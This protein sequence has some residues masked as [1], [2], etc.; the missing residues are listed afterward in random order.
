MF[1][2][3][4]PPPPSGSKPSAGANNMASGGRHTTFSVIGGDVII[5]GNLVATVDLHIDGR[6]D[7]DLRCANLV[8]GQDSQLRGAIVADSAKLA[9]LVEGSIDAKSLVIHASARIIGDVTYDSLTIEQGA[10][11]DGK[12][13]SRTHGA[14]QGGA[15]PA[16]LLVADQAAT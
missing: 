5:T 8:Q 16:L 10:H 15:A 2:R 6:I 14:G 13:T 3:S 1:S 7:G 9:G 4:K 11:V 12:L